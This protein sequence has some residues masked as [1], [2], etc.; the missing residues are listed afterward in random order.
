M[1]TGWK[2]VI[3]EKADDINFRAGCLVI[4]GGTTIPISDISA[5]M[6]TNEKA[7]ISIKLLNEL[8][9]EGINVIFCD[10]KHQPCAHLSC[11]INQHIDRAGRIIDQS[12]WN[13]EDKDT[14]WREIVKA[15]ITN[16]RL[17]LEN[18]GI[19]DLDD[20]IRYEQG[21][22]PGDIGNREG[23]AARIYFR[24]LFGSHFRR[25]SPDDINAALNYGYTI[26]MSAVC[27]ILV[28]HGYEPALGIHHRSRNNPYN[29]A[30]DLMEPFRPWVDEIVY[31]H[32]G[33]ELTWEYKQLFINLLYEVKEYDGKSSAVDSILE[34]YVLKTLARMKQIDESEG[35]IA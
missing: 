17:L 13:E 6:I 9:R 1:N 18:K 27:R 12:E 32:S 33:E 2:T 23:L 3:A 24:H 25:H 16:Q 4:D 22:M 7:C 30:C 34:T 31:E 15:K 20:L 10:S 35:N 26:L 28:L 11:S 21:V 8:C 19:T 5:L 29:L 14:I